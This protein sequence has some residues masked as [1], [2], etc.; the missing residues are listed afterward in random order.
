MGEEPL[1]LHFNRYP[2]VDARSPY[3]LFVGEA[4]PL[5]YKGRPEWSQNMQGISLLTHSEGHQDSQRLGGVVATK[6]IL[7][8]HPDVTWHIK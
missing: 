6:Q 5:F 2:I 7:T 3:R 8:P 1:L 4:L